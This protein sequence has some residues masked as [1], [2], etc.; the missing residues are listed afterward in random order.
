MMT[1]FPEIRRQ[2]RLLDI[3]SAL[4]LLERG[5]YGFLAMCSPLGYGYGLPISY[6][7]VPA[8]E[9]ADGQ[10]FGC[11]YV[12]CAPNGHKMDAVRTNDRVSFC[13]V[14]DTE[15]VPYSTVYESVHLFGHIR[16]V[17]DDKERMDALRLLRTKYNPEL[18][19]TSD[20]PILKSLQ[21]TVVLRLDIQHLAGKCKP[22]D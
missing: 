21:R 9:E 17:E 19:D 4:R 1:I 22:R 3:P 7:Y 2:D 12:H 5:E 13:V 20:V 15:V 8:S 14:G 10:D 18:A 16:I 11:V 6:V